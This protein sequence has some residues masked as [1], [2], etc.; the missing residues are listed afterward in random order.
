VSVLLASRDVCHALI[1]KG[2]IWLFLATIA[3]VPPVVS[4]ASPVYPSLLLVVTSS[5]QVFISL[6]WN[7]TCNSLPNL[8]VN[9]ADLT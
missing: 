1:F 9:T 6:N 3:E 7:R 4:V 8:S 5:S 2:L